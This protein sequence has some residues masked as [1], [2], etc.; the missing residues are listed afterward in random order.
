MGYSTDVIL[1][2]AVLLFALA[3]FAS[4]RIR[5]EI[6]ATTVLVTVALTGLVSPSDALSGFSNPAVVTVGAG[7]AVGAGLPRTGLAG[8]IG[9]SILPFAGCSKPRTVVSALRRRTGL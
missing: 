2:I 1:L 8:T 6:V 3:A 7:L 5:I 4:R 9:R